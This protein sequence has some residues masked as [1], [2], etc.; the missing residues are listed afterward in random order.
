[1]S[2]E[3]AASSRTM[4]R[5]VHKTYDFEDAAQWDRQQHLSLSPQERLRAARLLKDRAFPTDAP[6]VR[7]CRKTA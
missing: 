6:D 3:T 1:M 2:D 4:E 5:I 7:V